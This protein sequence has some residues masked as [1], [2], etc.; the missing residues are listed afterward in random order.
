GIQEAA[1]ASGTEDPKA[2]VRLRERAFI[3]R[4]RREFEGIAREALRAR[5]VARAMHRQAPVSKDP[6]LLAECRARLA[7]RG[8]MPLRVGPIAAAVMY[9]RELVLD[10]PNPSW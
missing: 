5:A 4:A 6:R 2:V 3:P 9:L 8:V 10:F 7:R 1:A